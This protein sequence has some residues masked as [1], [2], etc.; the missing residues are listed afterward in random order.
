MKKKF[1]NENEAISLLEFLESTD[2]HHS[3]IIELLFH[4]GMRCHELWGLTVG[5]LNLKTNV[6]TLWSGAK[7]SH[8]RFWELPIG[9]VSRVRSKVRKG[10]FGSKS[11]L[12]EALGYVSKGGS[13]DTFKS[14]LR[15]DWLVIRKRVWGVMNLGLHCLRHTFCITY[16]KLPGKE[17][18]DAQAAMGHKSIQSTALYAANFD[19][20]AHAKST[21]SMYEEMRVRVRGIK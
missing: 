16:F 17:L 7:G 6:L 1:L 8:G 14:I 18:T 12:V 3:M 5:D 10:G 21:A 15:R 19:D 13:A 9:Y 20:A 2:T 4:T 11:K